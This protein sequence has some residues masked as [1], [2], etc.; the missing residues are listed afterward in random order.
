MTEDCSFSSKTYTYIRPVHKN[1]THKNGRGEPTLLTDGRYTNYEQLG[2]VP[3]LPYINSYRYEAAS[4]LLYNWNNGDGKCHKLRRI[5]VDQNKAQPVPEWGRN[6]DPTRFLRDT[7]F[8]RD[9]ISTIDSL[10]ATFHDDFP[11]HEMADLFLRQDWH[12]FVLSTELYNAMHE[13]YF[14][15]RQNAWER[16]DRLVPCKN[17]TGLT[18]TPRFAEVEINSDRTS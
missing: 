1:F 13:F 2:W 15:H 8:L 7:H 5:F 14:G 16:L 3:I 17:A 18:M 12:A 6:R 4:R 9:T 11:F 10:W